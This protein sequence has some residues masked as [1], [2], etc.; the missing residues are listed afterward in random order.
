[1]SILTSPDLFYIQVWD[2]KARKLLL[3]LPGHSDEVRIRH[4]YVSVS[5]LISLAI[6][7]YLVM[8]N[9]SV[10]VNGH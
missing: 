6:W 5:K 2:I 1:M 7:Y 10:L 8:V 4:A 3:D 9:G